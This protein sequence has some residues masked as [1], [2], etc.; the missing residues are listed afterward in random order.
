MMMVPLAGILYAAIRWTMPDTTTLELWN[1]V[2]LLLA[3]LVLQASLAAPAFGYQV[4]MS[5][6]VLVV[7]GI[8][9]LAF[10]LTAPKLP[11]N[12]SM[13]IRLPWTLENEEVWTKT[14][15]IAGPMLVIG[16]V[17]LFIGAAI[18]VPM[19]LGILVGTAGPLLG[20]VVAS[21]VVWRRHG[22]AR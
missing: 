1:L 15:H 22:A 2:A 5:G 3:H 12:V 13:G 19:W 16:A 18:G 14:H 6:V 4:A 9:E 21:Y 17:L 10:G 20:A 7:L 8:I 11:P